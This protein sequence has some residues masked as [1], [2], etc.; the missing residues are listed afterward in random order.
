VSDMDLLR[1]YSAHLT[2][3]RGLRPNSVAAYRT[4][5]EQ[6]SEFASKHGAVLANASR[7]AVSAFLGELRG[8][9]VVSRSV[10]RKLSALRGFYLWLMKDKRIAHDPTLLVEQPT[11]SITLPHA[12]AAAQISEILDNLQASAVACD[13]RAGAAKFA[14]RDAAMLE[15]LYAA[16]LRVSELC[17]LRVEDLQLD[18]GR[19]QVRG[20]GDKE[21]IVPLGRRAVDALTEYLDRGRSQFVRGGRGDLQR[22]VFLSARGRALTRR[23]VYQLVRA[24]TGEGPHRIRHS[25]ATHMVEGGA[26]LRSVQTILGHADISTTQLYTHVAIRHLQETHRKFHPRSWTLTSPAGKPRRGR[27]RRAA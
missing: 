9:G 4:D 26:D 27:S 6:F 20:K 19:A 2:I 25:C 15:L 5:L 18:E 21:R 11:S 13:D 24:Q 3:E 22:A 23:W 14:L 12:T 16:G 7:E 1:E 17:G 8:N 10:S